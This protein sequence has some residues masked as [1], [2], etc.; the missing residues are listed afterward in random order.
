[1]FMNAH[2]VCIKVDREERPD[3]DQVYMDAVQLMTRQ[4]GWPLNC[5]AL[6]DGRPIWG[7]VY[8]PKTQWLSSLQAILDVQSEDPERVERY[9]EKLTA[10]VHAMGRPARQ[11]I[12]V[13][14]RVRHLDGILGPEHGGRT[15]APKFPLPCQLEFLGR[16]AHSTHLGPARRKQAAT[17]PCAPW[18][19][20]SL[21]ASTTMWEAGLRG[22]ASTKRGT[23]RILKRCCT[24]TRNWCPSFRR[25]RRQPSRIHGGHDEGCGVHGT[26]V[27]FGPWRLLCCA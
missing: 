2:F 23:F 10:A 12:V 21:A 14:R 22:T 25:G 8:L 15:G 6:P 3:V 24:T 17:T 5:I 26:G 27:A 9:A 4:G 1:M 11:R 16:A 13:S 20:W 7:S 18:T 19:P